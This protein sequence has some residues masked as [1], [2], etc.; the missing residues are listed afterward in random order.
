MD[1]WQKEWESTERDNRLHE[2]AT[3]YHTE[4]E[5]YDRTVCT[6]PMG[7]DGIM[8]ATPREM[9]L[10][11]RNAHVVRKRLMEKAARE[12][13]GRDELARAI[14]KWNGSLP[15]SMLS[16]ASAGQ[17][18]SGPHPMHAPCSWFAAKREGVAT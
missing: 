12:G 4:C 13:I 2:L 8:P 11:N 1:Q 5:S 15:N 18:P 14:S 9:A 16:G 17:H 10:I 6:G 7:R 3:R